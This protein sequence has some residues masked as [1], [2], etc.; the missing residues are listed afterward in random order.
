MAY[1]EQYL[2]ETQIH[3]IDIVQELAA[4]QAWDFNRIAEDQIAMAIEGAWRT[5]SITLDWS[6][7]DETLRMIC[8]FEMNPPAD[9]LPALY[10]TLNHANDKCWAGAFT[11]WSKQKLMAYRY[12]LVLTGGEIAGAHQINHLV[13]NA[14]A[15]C[16]KFYPA[17]QLATWGNDDPA[18]AMRV[19]MDEAYGTA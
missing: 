4:H 1:Q 5:Y 17:F 18:H 16:E 19:A 11:Y 10:E 14:I 12:G 9:T 3:P 8:S 15:S 6:E 13:R 2:D 7:I